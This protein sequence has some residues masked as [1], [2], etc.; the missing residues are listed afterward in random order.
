MSFELTMSILKQYKLSLKS[1]FES[2]TGNGDASCRFGLCPQNREI[3]ELLALER[4]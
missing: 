4:L 3:N 2:A 1:A